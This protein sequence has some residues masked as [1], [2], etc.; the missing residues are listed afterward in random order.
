MRDHA[1]PARNTDRQGALADRT[2][3]IH[4][5]GNNYQQIAGCYPAVNDF[6]GLQVDKC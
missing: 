6:K 2:L 4:E 5:F 1:R 3:I